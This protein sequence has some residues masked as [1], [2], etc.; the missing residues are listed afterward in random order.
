[1]VQDF[2]HQ[3]YEFSRK[4]GGLKT[5]LESLPWWCVVFFWWVGS[6]LVKTTFSS[7]ERKSSNCGR[8]NDLFVR[9]QKGNFQNSH[10]AISIRWGPSSYRWTVITSLNGYIDLGLFHPYKW[11]CFSLLITIVGSH[12][13]TGFFWGNSDPFFP[14]S[15][16]SPQIRVSETNLVVFLVGITIGHVGTRDFWQAQ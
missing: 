6:Y 8:I 14:M 13:G 16:E 9:S 3:Q 2:F 11:S 7:N 10:H 1:M 4:F 12:L 15:E 5:R